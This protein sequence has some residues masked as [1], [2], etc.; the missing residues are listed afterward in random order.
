MDDTKFLIEYQKHSTDNLNFDRIEK[1]L[2]GDGVDLNNVK[3]IFIEQNNSPKSKIQLNP[4]SKANFNDYKNRK[5]I[6]LHFLIDEEEIS[7]N[8]VYPVL[9]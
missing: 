2:E 8:K 1:L 9:S 3:Q 6:Y 5:N 4:L 7:K